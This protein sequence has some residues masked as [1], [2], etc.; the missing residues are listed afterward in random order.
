MLNEIEEDIFFKTL[1]KKHRS[2]NSMKEIKTEKINPSK[3]KQRFF[4]EALAYEENYGGN[5]LKKEEV[6]DENKEKI[7]TLKNGIKI[8]YKYEKNTVDLNDIKAKLSKIEKYDNDIMA[9]YFYHYGL[10]KKIIYY[11]K[12]RSINNINYFDIYYSIQTLHGISFI[13][14]DFLLEKNKY[15]KVKTL[16]EKDIKIYEKTDC[17]FNFLGNYPSNTLNKNSEALSL[18]ILKDNIE[19]DQ[20]DIKSFIGKLKSFPTIT[21]YYSNNKIIKKDI[22][23]VE[24]IVFSSELFNKNI[25][26]IGKLEKTEYFNENNEVEKVKKINEYIHLRN[27]FWAAYIP[28]IEYYFQEKVPELFVE[29]NF[30][31]QEEKF[32]KGLLE[33]YRTEKPKEEINLEEEIKELEEEMK[34]MEEENPSVIEEAEEF[35]QNLSFEDDDE[36]D[37]E[38]EEVNTEKKER[39]YTLKNKTKI[40]Y[41][42]EEDTVDLDD[43]EAKLLKIEKYNKDGKIE[44]ECFYHYGLLKKIIYYNEDQTINNVNYFDIYYNKEDTSLS[45]IYSSFHFY[46]LDKYFETKSLKESDIK[47]CVDTEYGSKFLENYPSDMI[48]AEEESLILKTLKENIKIEREDTNSYINDFESFPT[49]TEYY[50]NGKII[51]KDIYKVERIMKISDSGFFHANVRLRGVLEKTEYYNKE[52]KIEKIEEMNRY[53]YVVNAYFGGYL[54]RIKFQ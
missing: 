49:M 18:K 2:K 17:K 32:L 30:I 51:K 42:Y 10:L 15:F 54:P 29:E 5:A 37:L 44:V 9:E 41:K 40:I 7:F 19:I 52:N 8:I 26:L 25:I 13:N 16:K 1:L 38:S 45:Y 47:I 48:K 33:K 36:N 39:V 22:Y 43:W 24:R 4:F 34:R 50:R 31:E 28:R 3:K 6:N 14:S 21:E 12:D 27:A 20:R 11:N 23:K 46:K 35:W 53:I